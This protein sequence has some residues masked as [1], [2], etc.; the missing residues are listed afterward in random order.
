MTSHSFDDFVPY[1]LILPWFLDW[2]SW[3]LIIIARSIR[4]TLYL[5]SS[6]DIPKTVEYFEYAQKWVWPLYKFNFPNIIFV[7]IKKKKRILKLTLCFYPHNTWTVVAF[8]SLCI[9]NIEIMS[10]FSFRFTVS[11]QKI[12]IRML[13]LFFADETALKG[14]AINCFVNC[15]INRHKSSSFGFH[16]S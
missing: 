4:S 11:L 3:G 8:L 1:L 15:L 16:N 13:W 10:I 7:Y 12:L 14:E 5:F 9:I 6:V 2:T